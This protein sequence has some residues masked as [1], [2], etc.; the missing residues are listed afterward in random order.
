MY[1]NVAYFTLNYTIS[2]HHNNPHTLSSH[3]VQRKLVV[4]AILPKH[5][6]KRGTLILLN[7]HNVKF[8]LAPVSSVNGLNFFVL[9]SV[10]VSNMV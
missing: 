3:P 5:F 4:L 6:S 8:F 2:L 1:L 9:R 10:Y 7:P